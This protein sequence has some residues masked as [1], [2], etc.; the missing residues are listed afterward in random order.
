MCQPGRDAAAFGSE[1]GPIDATVD[2]G[3]EGGG[4]SWDWSL[5]AMAGGKTVAES[6]AV[7]DAGGGA[8]GGWTGAVLAAGCVIA[9]SGCGFTVPGVGLVGETSIAPAA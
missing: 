9:G 3:T 6:D 4:E 7:G 8:N 2:T 5:R 1:T